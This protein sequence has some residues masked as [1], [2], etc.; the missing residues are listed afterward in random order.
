M[1]AELDVSHLLDMNEALWRALTPGSLMPQSPHFGGVPRFLRCWYRSLP[2]GV[3]TM[4]FLFERVGYLKK[5]S[6]LLVTLK[7]H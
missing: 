6:V 3:L 5:I 7:L 2:P 4:R 1:Q